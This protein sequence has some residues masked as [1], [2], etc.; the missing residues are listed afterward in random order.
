[1]QPIIASVCVSNCEQQK[2][3]RTVNND[4][5]STVVYPAVHLLKTLLLA[6]VGQV[7]TEAMSTLATL[8]ATL[9]WTQND[10]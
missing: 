5:H 1:M 2:P 4:I 3:V 7:A 10:T 6:Q 9:P 8:D